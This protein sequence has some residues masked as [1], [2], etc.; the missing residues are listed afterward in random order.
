MSRISTFL[1]WVF[2]TQFYLFSQTLEKENQA[3]TTK[4]SATKDPFSWGDF[5]WLQGNNRQK[6]ALLDGDYFTGS[7]TMDISYTRSSNNPIDHTVVGSTASFRTNELALNYIEFG[8]DF[9]HHNV[10]ARL[11]MQLGLRSTG[12]PRNDN[13][14][15]RG[16]YDL[17]TALR[18]LTEGYAGYHFDT[19]EGINVDFGIFKS[20]VGLNSYNNFENWNYQPSY[21]SDNTPWFFTGARI[22][23][24]PSKKLKIEYWLVN[25]WQTFGM[26]NESPGIGV[27]TVYR[28]EEWLS[29][30]GSAY[31]GYDTPTKKDRIRF[32]SDNSIVA[33]YHNN[34]SNPISKA[35]FS[36]TADIGFENGDGVSPFGG[37]GGPAQNFLSGML[38]H[39][40]WFNEDKLAWTVGGGY[41]NSP[42]RYLILLPTGAGANVFTQNPGD[43]FEAWDISTTMQFMPNEYLTYFVEYVYRYANVPY[44]AG[45]GGVTSPNG[46]NSPI[47]DPT[48]FIPD[49]VNDEHRLMLGLLV[50]F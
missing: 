33:R 7:V 19:W 24:Y 11:M 36:L 5:T 23:T 17:Y 38:Y 22:Q 25:G 16:Q 4:H 13:S 2:F 49:L 21:T 29:L 28:P 42:G 46:F 31:F 47:G 10:R 35:A 30:V 39:R 45:R 1:V 41:I 34:K 48:N 12:I 26:F 27:Q 9:H 3:D 15:L 43:K 14:G 6:S 44:F 18:Y 20:Y 40:L 8:G 37:D 50:R 32:H